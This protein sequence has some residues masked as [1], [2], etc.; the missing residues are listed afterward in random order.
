[1]FRRVVAYKEQHGNTNTPRIYKED[2]QLGNW[3]S[4][5][6]M[7]HTK[8]ILSKDRLDLL[9]SIE[10]VWEI[11]NTQ[12]MKMYQR[13][14]AYKKQH[15]TTS[16]PRHYKDDQQLAI[17]VKCQRADY[18]NKKLSIERINYLESIGFVWKIRCD[19]VPWIEM[20]ERLVAYK[21]C[22][23]STLVARRYTENPRLGRWSTKQRVKYNKGKLSEKQMQL[24]NSIDFVRFSQE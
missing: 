7:N 8:G 10:F 1:M 4:R 13:L 12:W 17:W 21:Q 14:I 6:R 11:N 20:Y 5:Q 16:V 2:P 9:N 22:H 3:V 18:K 24:L 19:Y 23:Q 15:K